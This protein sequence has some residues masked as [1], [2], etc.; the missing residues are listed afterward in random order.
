LR[1]G[2]YPYIPSQGSLGASGDLAPLSHLALVLTGEAG[3]RIYDP[4]RKR[5]GTYESRPSPDGFIEA[6]PAVLRAHGYEP[7]VLEAKEGLALN[8]G[9]Q[10]MTAIGLLTI[11]DAERLQVAA[12]GACAMSFEALK[13]VK[14]AFDPRIHAARPH[15]G[16]QQSAEA[17]RHYTAGSQILRIPL[18]MAYINAAKRALKDATF[19][20]TTEDS[21]LVEALVLRVTEVLEGLEVLPSAPEA[22]LKQSQGG[23]VNDLEAYR[24][25]LGREKK[26][27]S[28]IYSALLSNR[29]GGEV[30]QAQRSLSVALGHLESA[31]PA[32][33]PVQDNYS[34]RCSPQVLGAVR[35]VVDHVMGV[36]LIEA[37]SAT[38]NPLIIPPTHDLKGRPLPEDDLEA[39]TA[40]LDEGLCRS[41]V[42][43]GGNFHGEPVAFAMDYLAIG[44]AEVGSISER[45][46]AHLVDGNLNQGL[47]SLLT[48][49][50]GLNS[51]FMVPQYTAASL[52][53]E[54]KSLAHPASVDSIPSCENTEDHVSMGTIAARKALRILKSVEEVVA[55]EL[56]TAFQALHFRR[57]LVPG[58]ASLELTALLESKG[59]SFVSEDRPLYLDIERCTAL[60]RSGEVTATLESLVKG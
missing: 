14:D 9:T 1:L 8:N 44:L 52:V 41:C 39:Y 3:G 31:V 16:Q 50:A 19:Y 21:P 17:L 55:I 20:L 51:G 5:V 46:V 10:V 33:P 54:N 15:R 4:A 32:M 40:S 53:S 11:H 56:L 48:D 7:I 6:T 18:N 24:A 2:L 49:N 38:D 45:R 43:S 59:V 34:L 26:A 13:G 47:P 25:A 58:Y 60:I 28:G 23:A 35:Q 42:R 30:H 27:L 12:E 37:N 57:P 36:L 29:F 22:P